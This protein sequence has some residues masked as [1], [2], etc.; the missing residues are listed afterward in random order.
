M[1][2]RFIMEIRDLLNKDGGFARRNSGLQSHITSGSTPASVSS[3]ILARA[4]TKYSPLSSMHWFWRYIY[5]PYRQ[6]RFKYI[7]YP[8]IKS[9]NAFLKP[10]Q[11][12]EKI[13]QEAIQEKNEWKAKYIQISKEIAKLKRQGETSK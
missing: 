8:L 6:V 10:M 3:S 1:Y 9:T 4:S 2:G 5:W 13:T 7:D 11:E 12:M